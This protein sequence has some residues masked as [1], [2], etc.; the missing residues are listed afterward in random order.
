MYVHHVRKDVCSSSCM[1]VILKYECM[2]VQCPLYFL[3][4]H[5][6]TKLFRIY[7]IIHNKTNLCFNYAVYIH[8]IRTLSVV[9]IYSSYST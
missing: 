5:A 6:D 8:S 1:E 2:T 4:S 7:S 9:S 3:Y